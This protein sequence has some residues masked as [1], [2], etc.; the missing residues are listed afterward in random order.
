MTEPMPQQLYRIFRLRFIAARNLTILVY[1]DADNNLEGAGVKDIEK[2]DCH[3]KRGSTQKV[4]S[5]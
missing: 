3:G 2:C 5:I 1:L 4:C